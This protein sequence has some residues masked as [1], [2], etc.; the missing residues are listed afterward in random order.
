[1]K[2][3][4][5]LGKGLEV[6]KD[7]KVE[8]RVASK[9]TA[10]AAFMLLQK[11]IG[12]KVIF[13]GGHTKGI[14]NSSEARVMFDFAKQYFPE[15]YSQKII[16][17]ENSIDT[18]GNAIEVK[19]LVPLDVEIILL[20]ISFHLLRSKKIFESYAI[21]INHSFASEKVLKESLKY[22]FVLKQYGWRTRIWEMI[23]EAVGL[24][25][26]YTIDPKGMILRKITSRTRV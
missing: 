22:D 21:K 4:I 6:L 20:T 8:P 17:E 15:I 10:L 19:K 7:G 25:F 14:N 24:L 1:M 11:G 3:I 23:W 18:A 5:A 9:I 12:D 16:L 2:Y 13:S 26:A